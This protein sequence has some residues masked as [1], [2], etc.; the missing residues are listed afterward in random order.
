MSPTCP[1]PLVPFSTH[2]DNSSDAD[3]DNDAAADADT[4]NDNNSDTIIDT[5]SDTE[6]DTDID[7]IFFPRGDTVS[8]PPDGW[9]ASAY[10]AMMAHLLPTA[11]DSLMDVD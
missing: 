2:N 5:D 11:I 9:P 8:S 1:S 10:N 4:D 6:T 7:D 3:T